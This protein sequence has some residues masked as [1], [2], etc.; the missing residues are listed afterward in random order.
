MLT[1]SF[2]PLETTKLPTLTAASYFILLSL[3]RSPSK[4]SISIA[5]KQ[6]YRVCLTKWFNGWN[7]DP[8]K[9]DVWFY[10]FI[11][12]QYNI[13]I[14]ASLMTKQIYAHVF[15]SMIDAVLMKTT[16][17]N[18]INDRLCEFILYIVHAHVHWYIIIYNAFGVS[19]QKPGPVS[20]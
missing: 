1:K 5:T 10:S 8:A 12:L 20:V 2:C 6:N 3:S 4:Y 18:N 16:S 13:S 15:T 19:K 14:G 7:R 17:R 9:E 11:T